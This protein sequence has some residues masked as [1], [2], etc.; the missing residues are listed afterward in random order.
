M[1][2]NVYF[3]ALGLAA[4]NQLLENSNYSKTI[5]LVDENTREKCLPEFLSMSGLAPDGVATIK[6]GEE[7][8]NIESCNAVWQELADFGCDRKSLLINLG[9]GV[10]TD[11]GGFAA[12]TFKRGIDFV[13]VP[14]T[15]LSMVDASI[16]GKTGIDFGALKNQIGTITQPQLVL[17]NPKFLET[18]SKREFISGYAE[19]LKHGLIANIDHWETLKQKK[20]EVDASDIEVSTMVKAAIVKIDPYERNERKKLNF[21]HTL[22]H[23]IESYYLHHAE[24]SKLLHGEAIA[25]GMILEAYL[26]HELA[27][28]SKVSV[29][30]VKSLI[31]KYFEKIEIDEEEIPI[32]IDLMKHD[33]KNTHGNINFVLLRTIGSAIVDCAVSENLIYDAFAY[34]KDE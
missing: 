33:K 3:E 4:L 20:L 7:F 34:Y 16:G 31:F 24:K 13:N 15:L 6:A 8:K 5:I 30:E 27:G 11:L 21:G 25:V 29:N 23:A 12:S 10:V 18:L 22:G 17:I 32:I 19:M 26:S 28:L 14:T 1:Q 9:G 2:E